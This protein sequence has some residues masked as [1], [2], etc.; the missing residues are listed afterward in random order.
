[1]SDGSEAI[2]GLVIAGSFVGWMYVVIE[3]D[4]VPLWGKALAPIYLVICVLDSM[5]DSMWPA[6]KN[7]GCPKRTRAKFCAKCG[8][9]VTV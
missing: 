1:M 7:C 2:M 6:C 9:R 8:K 5:R 3:C 4:N